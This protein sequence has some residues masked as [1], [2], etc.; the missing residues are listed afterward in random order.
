MAEPGVVLFD[1][2]GVVLTNGWDRVSRQE[3]CRAFDLDWEDFQDRHDFV[4]DAFERGELDLDTYL[5]RTVF[6]RERPFSPSE[7]AGYMRSRSA[8]IDGARELVEAIA[9]TGRYLLV[10]LNNE[11]REMNEHRIEQFDL[12]SLFSAFLS[13]CYLGVRK[14]EPE[15]YRMAVD[16]VQRRPEDCVFV[17]D[18]ELNLECAVLAGIR[19]VLATGTDSVAAGLR[20]HGIR[21]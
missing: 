12:R 10:T 14:P 8:P 2:G 21:F 13:S 6:Y 7:F 17:D 18:R 4:A 16:I 5:Q 3:A 15:I 11:S 20:D 19:P 9:A 1:V